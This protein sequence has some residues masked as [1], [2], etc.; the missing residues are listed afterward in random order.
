MR[1]HLGTDVAKIAAELAR[2]REFADGAVDVT[3][4]RETVP[5]PVWA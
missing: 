1:L 5:T 4:Q 3:T 2:H